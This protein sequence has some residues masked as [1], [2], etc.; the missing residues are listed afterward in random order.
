MRVKPAF[1]TQLPSSAK[2]QPKAS[3]RDLARMVLENAPPQSV[4]VFA[5]W[6][7]IQNSDLDKIASNC[8]DGKA[9]TLVCWLLSDTVVHRYVNSN[10]INLLNRSLI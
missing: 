3:P 10:V 2:Q 1:A 5:D 4:H 6:E 8:V 7:F 9:E